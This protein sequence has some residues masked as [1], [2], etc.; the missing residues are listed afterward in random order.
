[1]SVSVSTPRLF[2]VNIIECRL[3][4]IT[5][6][7]FHSSGAELVLSVVNGRLDVPVGEQNRAARSPGFIQAGM[8][9]KKLNYC[10]E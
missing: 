1:M 6:R 4:F 10:S 2:L 8:I 3:K 7:V 9:S 5:R